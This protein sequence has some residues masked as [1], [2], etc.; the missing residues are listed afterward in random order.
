M[1]S[2][3]SLL[4]GGPKVRFG[5][6]NAERSYAATLA[7]NEH[8]DGPEAFLLLYRGQAFMAPKLDRFI[9]F[10]GENQAGNEPGIRHLTSW[11]GR[12]CGQH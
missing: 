12:Q 5:L 7:I 6:P 8:P 2:T 9:E 11:S 1:E 10:A 3:L 4:D